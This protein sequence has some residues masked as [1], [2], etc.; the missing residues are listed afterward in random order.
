MET[1]VK[2]KDEIKTTANGENK[3]ASIR[4]MVSDMI[5][6]KTEDKFVDYLSTLEAEARVAKLKKGYEK[7]ESLEQDLKKENKPDVDPIFDSEGVV[8][9]PGGFSK[10]FK[11]KLDEKKKYI[12]DFKDAFANAISKGDFSKFD[13]FIGGK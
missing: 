13:K 10:D 12:D 7:L 1:N 4:K 3:L 6:S 9:R 11:K 5:T 2:T 8:I